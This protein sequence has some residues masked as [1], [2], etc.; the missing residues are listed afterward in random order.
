MNITHPSPKPGEQ[1]SNLSI[2][3]QQQSFGFSPMQGSSMQGSMNRQMRGHMQQSSGGWYGGQPNKSN[4]GYYTQGYFQS[5][6]KTQS[7][8]SI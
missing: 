2:Q 5:G 4:N 8:K 7:G 1:P 3:M 6:G